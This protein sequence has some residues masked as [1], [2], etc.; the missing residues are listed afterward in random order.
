MER[1]SYDKPGMF[2]YD[3]FSDFLGKTAVIFD[4]YKDMRNR[5]KKKIII[6]NLTGVE[7]REHN[8]TRMLKG[9]EDTEERTVNVLSLTMGYSNGYEPC[10]YYIRDKFVRAG[11]NDD[12]FSFQIPCRKG[13]KTEFDITSNQDEFEITARKVASDETKTFKEFMSY[14]RG[15][16]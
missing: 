11:S 13:I 4:I 6:G 7:I 15:L 9:G 14:A 10:L 8:I 12:K 1:F 3:R 2:T 5:K 16:W